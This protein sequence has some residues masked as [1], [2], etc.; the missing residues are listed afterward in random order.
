MKTPPWA[1]LLIV[2]SLLGFG[3]TVWLFI[4]RNDALAAANAAQIE[5][6]RAIVEL[7]TARSQLLATNEQLMAAEQKAKA[8]TSALQKQRAEMLQL[9]KLNAD[10]RKEQNR[11]QQDMTAAQEQQASLTDALAVAKIEASQLQ[12][13]ISSLTAALKACDQRKAVVPLS[14]PPLQSN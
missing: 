4:E 9:Q 2:A 13:E 12:T 6:Q 7:N 14:T 3:S 11:L 10:F 5:S 1:V 8:V